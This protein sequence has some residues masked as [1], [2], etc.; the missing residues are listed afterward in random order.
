MEKKSK[1]ADHVRKLKII[2]NYPIIN[3]NFKNLQ[4]FI[5]ARKV[6]TNQCYTLAVNDYGDLYSW[7]SNKDG[8]L[9]QKNESKIDKGD[10]IENPRKYDFF[11]NKYFKITI[12]YLN[13]TRK[14]VP[15]L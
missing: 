4:K 2:K 12:N 13:N 14:I 7:G 8:R 9:G 1:I 3:I 5:P 6:A 15:N 10:I 11:P